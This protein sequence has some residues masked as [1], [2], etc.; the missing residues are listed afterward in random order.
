MLLRLNSPIGKFDIIPFGFILPGKCLPFNDTACAEQFL[1]KFTD[2]PHAWE[3]LTHLHAKLYR[4]ER[5][6]AARSGTVIRQL[7]QK[8]NGYDLYICP[9]VEV[10]EGVTAYRGGAGGSVV[11]LKPLPRPRTITDYQRKR[12]TEPRVKKIQKYKIVIEVVGQSPQGVDGFFEV[13]RTPDGDHR[14]DGAFRRNISRDPHRLVISIDD[15][16]NKPR[17]LRYVVGTDRVPLAKTISPVTKETEKGEWDHVMI[18]VQLLYCSSPKNTAKATLLP[19]GWLYVFVNGYLWRELRVHNDVGE[20]SD[21]EFG[22]HAGKDARNCTGLITNLLLLPHKINGQRQ[23]IHMAHS[24]H[25]WRWEDIGKAGGTDPG[26]IR[27]SPRIKQKT[28]NIATDEAMINKLQRIDLSSYQQGFSSDDPMVEPIA[29]APNIV[30][31]EGKRPDMISPFRGH[32]IPAVYLQAGITYIAI[33][34]V[35]ADN[36]V[37]GDAPYVLHIG[38]DAI[39]GR[40]TVDGIVRAAIPE[41]IVIVTLVVQPYDDDPE[42]TVSYN[43]SVGKLDI[44][45]NITGQQGRLRNLGYDTGVVDGE[46]GQVTQNAIEQFQQR[47]QLDVSAEFDDSTKSKLQ[48]HLS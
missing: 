29:Q 10:E 20:I 15:V 19:T 27:L 8:L 24:R 6:R 11:P 38:D 30:G 4:I 5:V 26:D 14:R 35:D 45:S 44:I 18:P 47:Q 42:D 40:S 46:V 28:A 16:P 43:I 34:L 23:T 3:Q 22:H 21:V 41:N 17:E 2:Y 13:T 1:R 7:A 39:E 9:V 31:Y 12:W 32:N 48:S 37:Y 33:K 36:T 25:Q